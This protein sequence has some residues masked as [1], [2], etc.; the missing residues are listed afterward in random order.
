M[1]PGQLLGRSRLTG[2]RVFYQLAIA[3]RI[4][5]NLGS[6]PHSGWQPGAVALGALFGGEKESTFSLKIAYLP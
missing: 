3:A 6:L 2:L 4:V 1:M 5:G